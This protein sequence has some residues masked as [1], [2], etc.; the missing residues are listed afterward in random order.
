MHFLQKLG[1]PTLDLRRIAGKSLA[2]R[3]A[4]SSVTPAHGVWQLPVKPARFNGLDVDLAAV[5]DVP[6]LEVLEA[7]LN[8][9]LDTARRE[10]KS[11]VWLRLRMS[12]GQCF[13]AAARQGFIFHHAEGD[14]AMLHIWL[15]S[16]PCPVP[17]FAT[18]V[19]GVAGVVLDDAQ[20]LLVVKDKGKANAFK[21]PGGLAN[22]GEDFGETA[23][24][25]TR[26]ET[27]VESTFA[28][29]LA[30]RH[31]HGMTWGRSDI[32]LLCRLRPLTHEIVIDPR[33]IAEAR[34]MDAA[35]YIA[36]TSHPLNKF[37]AMAA[38][39]DLH[40]EKAG[41]AAPRTCLVEE[42]VF[43]P[44]TGKTVKCYRSAAAQEI[45]RAQ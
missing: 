9:M 18:H 35:E 6:S 32:Y 19:V 23:V 38:L 28:S 20:R 39:E 3:W 1:R 31:Q 44:V 7:S 21:F 13:A 42:Q 25:E 40:R 33:E 15:P 11:S 5:S 24:R 43:I 36:S 8:Q 12:Q 4:H 22:L 27:G 10:D 17:P 41:A 29:M 37:V 45:V 34:W 26:E 30:F 2:R 16:S 14:V